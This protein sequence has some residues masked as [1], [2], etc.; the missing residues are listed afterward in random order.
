MQGV[1]AVLVVFLLIA[2]C[3]HHHWLLSACTKHSEIC[4]TRRVVSCRIV[5]FAVSCPLLVKKLCLVAPATTDA[6]MICAL[7]RPLHAPSSQWSQPTNNHTPVLLAWAKDD[8]ALWFSN[9]KI[10]SDAL[11]PSQLKL[12]AAE[13]GGH[14]ILPEYLEPMHAFVQTP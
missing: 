13:A 3:S 4:I 14:R 6:A 7:A 5:Q 10:W 1:V 2:S 11:K 9:S 8:K 12:V